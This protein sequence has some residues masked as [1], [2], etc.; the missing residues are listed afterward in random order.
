MVTHWLGVIGTTKDVT[1]LPPLEGHILTHV[2]TPTTLSFTGNLCSCQEMSFPSLA[3]N[4]K[5]HNQR[6]RAKLWAEPKNQ[7]VVL[8]IVSQS[9]EYCASWTKCLVRMAINWKTERNACSLFCKLQVNRRAVILIV[10]AACQTVYYNF[11]K[12]DSEPILW[13]ADHTFVLQ[14]SFQR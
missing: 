9:F 14:I 5:D 10:F 13:Y 12:N 1:Q 7:N 8:I 11:P 2:W 6:M 3:F 4:V